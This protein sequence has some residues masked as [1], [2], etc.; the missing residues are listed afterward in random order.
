[1]PQLAGYGSW[2]SP[3]SAGAIAA[4]TIRLGQV[5]VDGSDVYWAELRPSEGGRKVIVRRTADGAVSD[6]TPAGF[7]ARTRVHEYGGGAYAVRNGVV[8][9]ANFTDQR[10]YRQ[11][12]GEDAQALTPRAVTPED[13]GW[14]YADM[15]IDDRRDRVI[16]VREDHS[17]VAGVAGSGDAE[18]VNTVVAV[19]ATSGANQ[20]LVEGNDFY[21]APRIDRES[22]RLAWLTWNHPDMP[23]DSTEL[24]VAE[25]QDDGTL[26]EPTRVAGGPGESVL[27][28]LWAGDGS[29]IFI[30]DRSGW[31]N[32][33][34]W[35]PGADEASDGG[36]LGAPLTEKDAEFAAPP[37]SFGQA[38]Y[39]FEPAPGGGPERIICEYAENGTSRLARLDIATRELEPID[40]PYT[41]IASV[42]VANGRIF[43]RGGS[44][45]TSAVIAQLDTA[46]GAVDVLRRTSELTLDSRYIS[47]P[48]AIEFP[49]ENGKTAHGFFYRPVNPDHTAPEGEKPPL[50]VFSHGG[51]TAATSS[52]LSLAIQYWTSRGVAV[53]D[54]NYGGSSGHGRAYR[55]RLNGQWGI[56]DVD[57]CANAARYL[58]ARGDADG[59]AWRF[60]AAAPA[61]TPRSRR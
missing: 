28:P 23:W 41:S 57:D 61:A 22:G 39:G 25:F 7:N 24:W 12:A 26:G 49:T 59:S 13:S 45:T 52:V 29:L 44:P 37:W 33:Y 9:F 47:E 38:T 21:A 30:S 58:V 1:M 35:Q 54:V 4:K 34:R 10:L 51:P 15:V 42:H 40:V 3:L 2:K 20:V 56:V 53:V 14:R 48:E 18:A 32:L 27:Q 8:Y 16:C 43:I 5:T 60:A 55:E 36:R 19:D 31:W 46:T 17:G 50:V 6:L 11:T